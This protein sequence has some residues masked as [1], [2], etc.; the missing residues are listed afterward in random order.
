MTDLN[1][2]PEIL[3]RSENVYNHHILNAVWLVADA[4]WYVY[5]N[6]KLMPY[7]LQCNSVWNFSFF[8]MILNENWMLNM[9]G[10]RTRSRSIEDGKLCCQNR[11]YYYGNSFNFIKSAKKIFASSKS[12]VKMNWFS[13][14]VIRTLPDIDER[15]MYWQILEQPS[16][17]FVV[18]V[19]TE[20]S[21]YIYLYINRQPASADRHRY[22]HCIVLMKADLLSL[23]HI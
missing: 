18:I 17:G 22:S 15:N 20:R 8:A 21:V 1:S 11:N 3:I 7:G 13:A 2:R 19:Q 5:I 16:C 9:C 12:M 4:N 23:G 10:V 14:S 6:M